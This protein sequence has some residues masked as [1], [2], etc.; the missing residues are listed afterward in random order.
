M[1]ASD[2][3]DHHHSGP[4]SVSPNAAAM[5]SAS[6]QQEQQHARE[7]GLRQPQALVA[8]GGE[9]G[10]DERPQGGHVLS[11]SRFVVVHAD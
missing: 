8:V 9:E 10:V 11:M 2:A 5:C 6:T 4:S 1:P 7:P 3:A